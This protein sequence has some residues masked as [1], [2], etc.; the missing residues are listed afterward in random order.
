MTASWSPDRL[1][2]AYDERL[3]DWK[4]G[5]EHPT[6]P[7][8]AKLGPEHPTNPVRAKLAIEALA[9]L[10]VQ[11]DV[12]PISWQLTDELSLVHTPDY[13][14]RTLVEGRNREW[15]GV[16]PNLGA[17]AAHMFAGTVQLAHAI[18]RGDVRVGFSP[19]GAKHHPMADRGSGFCVFN[20]MAWAAKHFAAQGKRVLYVDLDAHHGDGVEALIRAEPLVMTCS[21]HDSTI[22]PG[23]GHEHAPDEHV[24]NYPLLAG[25]G[26]EALMSSLERIT[27]LGESWRP[28]V[29]L[30]A[31][32]ADG[33]ETDPL[34]TLKYT[35][36]G[37][38]AAAESLGRLAA[39]HD[40]PVLLGGA[41]G[42]QPET[43]TPR[44]WAA[45]VARL[46]STRRGEMA[47]GLCGA[48]DPASGV[49]A[50]RTIDPA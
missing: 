10:R 31:I 34:S 25:S 30:I 40:A 7:V 49:C 16:Q 6:N 27:A 36:D 22:F 4:L 15:S 23:T 2:V 41:G 29:V 42:Y 20:D 33:H 37:Y 18:E 46:Y 43:H 35:Y 50:P 14:D 38:R 12:Q 21:V 11:M 45:F 48:H 26:D 3:L 1:A 28:Q 44:V 19:Q 24:Y 13:L 39:R 9:E 5:P 47:D 8:R 17:V 32:G